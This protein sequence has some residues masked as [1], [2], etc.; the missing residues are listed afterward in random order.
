MP[1]NKYKIING[2]I[3]EEVHVS[4]VPRSFLNKEALAPEK[5]NEEQEYEWNLRSDFELPVLLLF[6]QFLNYLEKRGTTISLLEKKIWESRLLDGMNLKEIAEE[7][8]LT[9][10]QIKKI[11]ANLLKK[12]NSFRDEFFS[13]KWENKNQN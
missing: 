12:V 10:D 2:K 1:N 8:G 6:N 13:K 4:E 3:Y 9:L 5:R 11:S 7:T